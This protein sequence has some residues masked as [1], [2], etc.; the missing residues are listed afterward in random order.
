MGPERGNIPFFKFSRRRAIFMSPLEI[1]MQEHRV[2]EQVLACLDIITRQAEES[3]QLEADAARD[4][5]DFLQQYADRCHHGKEE[6]QL[7]PMLEER[8][9]PAE[10]GPTGVMRLEHQQGR[11]LV[12]RMVNAIDGAAAGEKS[13]L[14]EFT[15]AGR[16]FVAL[17]QGHIDK[18]DHCLFPMAQQTLGPDGAEELA[19]AFT[20]VEGEME[21][22]LAEKYVSIAAALAGRYGV[23][24]AT[25]SS[26]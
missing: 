26:D 4:A 11:Q 3:G 1:L 13:A 22:G 15:D 16:K 9:M 6:D 18:E 21:P 12:I 8:G 20:R 7:F 25:G 23:M 10:G 24:A 17:L 5:T 19:R 2:I 14:D